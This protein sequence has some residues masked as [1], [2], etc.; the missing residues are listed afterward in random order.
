MLHTC[1]LAFVLR[2]QEQ[3]HMRAAQAALAMFY[4][5][6]LL[7]PRGVCLEAYPVTSCVLTSTIEVDGT[8]QCNHLLQVLL[9]VCLSV[10]LQCLVQVGHIRG[11]VL[12]VVQLHD[13][14]TDHRLWRVQDTR[15]R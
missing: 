14:A 2:R 6:L 1:D 15:G 5:N 10:L 7:A 11:M 9:A 13:L 8:L 12:F 3:V 4:Y